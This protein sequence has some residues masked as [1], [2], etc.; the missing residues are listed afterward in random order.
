MKCLHAHVAY[1]LAGGD[2]PVGRWAIAHLERNPDPGGMTLR[3]DDRTVTV[4]IAD[5]DV[6]GPGHDRRRDV[7]SSRSDR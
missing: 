7:H 6:D 2:D 5:P 1:A 3:I 4:T